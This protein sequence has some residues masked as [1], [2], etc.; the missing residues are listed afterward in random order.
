MTNEKGA[1]KKWLSDYF[2]LFQ[3][4]RFWIE[5]NLKELPKEGDTL[6]VKVYPWEEGRDQQKLYQIDK[7]VHG[8][9]ELPTCL[10]NEILDHATVNSLATSL[11]SISTIQNITIE[12]AIA[13][14]SYIMVLCMDYKLYTQRADSF[15]FSTTYKELFQEYNGD[16]QAAKAA[17]DEIVSTPRFRIKSWLEI[18]DQSGVHINKQLFETPGNQSFV[19]YRILPPVLIDGPADAINPLNLSSQMVIIHPDS[20]KLLTQNIYKVLMTPCFGKSKDESDKAK[21]SITKDASGW[22]ISF[23]G[24]E[25]RFN[26]HY[27]GLSYIAEL[28]DNADFSFNAVELYT[29]IKGDSSAQTNLSQE[30]MKQQNMTTQIHKVEAIDSTTISDCH[31]RLEKLKQERAEA[32]AE[33]DQVVLSEIDEEIQQIEDY[34]SGS[35]NHKG[36]ARSLADNI[37]VKRRAIHNAVTLVYSKI[38]DA[39]LKPF[40]KSHIHIGR[41]CKYTSIDSVNWQVIV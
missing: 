9:Y 35:L 29:K 36:K 10:F 5:I 26:R 21:Y 17:Y 38:Q 41:T 31:Q 37:D 30:I 19:D 12:N 28:V 20:I 23:N 2:N 3:S 24:R 13:F 16:S 11:M 8:C 18:W 40:L 33:D 1:V 15:L 25:T 32:I 4:F 27:D 14:L 22:R 39:S 6:I 34:L 7:Y